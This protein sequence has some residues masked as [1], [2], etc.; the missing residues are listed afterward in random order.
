ME[1]VDF[2][3]RQ[4]DQFPLFDGQGTTSLPPD[5]TIRVGLARPSH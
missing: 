2:T 3:P 1:I 4:L 5:S